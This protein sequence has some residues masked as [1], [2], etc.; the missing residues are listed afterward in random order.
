MAIQD[1]LCPNV[2]TQIATINHGSRPDSSHTDDANGQNWTIT[3]HASGGSN[4]DR[5]N[6]VIRLTTTGQPVAQGGSGDPNYFCRYTTIGELLY[7]GQG[8]RTGD[9]FDFWMGRAK[10]KITITKH[11][12][13]IVQANLGLIRPDPTPFDNDSADLLYS[14]DVPAFKIASADITDLPLNI[15]REVLQ[16]KLHRVFLNFQPL[17]YCEQFHVLHKLVNHT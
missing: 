2:K 11:S 16:Q 5:K 7:G 9:W 14:L 1:A 17:V 6:L 10:Y 3:V 4:S 8:W 13:S 15:S 12:E